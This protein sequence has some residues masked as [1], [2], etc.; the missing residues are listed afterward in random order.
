MLPSVRA[1]VKKQYAST[2]NGGPRMRRLMRYTAKVVVASIC[3]HLLLPSK[4][5]ASDFHSF[6][7]VKK[8]KKFSLTVMQ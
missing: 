2:S 7:K 4:R 1:L 8:D 5:L 3:N 6:S